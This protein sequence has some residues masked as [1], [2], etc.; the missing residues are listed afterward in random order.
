MFATYT[1]LPVK[2]L[3]RIHEK[4]ICRR[5]GKRTRLPALVVYA[6]P[7]RATA[8]AGGSAAR[9]GGDVCVLLCAVAGV[10]VLGAGVGGDA[11]LV[12]ALLR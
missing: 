7:L 4:P 11:R 5:S 8:G 3:G 6:S 2:E 1:P 12:R 9:M 10:G